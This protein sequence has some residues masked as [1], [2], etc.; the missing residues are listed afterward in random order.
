MHRNANAKFS[1]TQIKTNNRS[2]VFQKHVQNHAL[3]IQSAVSARQLAFYDARNN[4]LESLAR[5]Q[6]PA[7]TQVDIILR[8][9][10]LDSSRVNQIYD[11]YS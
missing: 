7:A 1:K 6:K 2:I 4:F 8:V 10:T 3:F 11:L 9:N 5:K